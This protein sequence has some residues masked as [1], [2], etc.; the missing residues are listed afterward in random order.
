MLP[1]DHVNNDLKKNLNSL[2]S[3]PIFCLIRSVYYQKFRDTSIN[4]ILDSNV[5]R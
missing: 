5:S 3:T 4:I 1:E 2:T